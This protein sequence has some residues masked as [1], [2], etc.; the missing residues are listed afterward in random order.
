MFTQLPTELRLKV[1]EKLLEG[2]SFRTKIFLEHVPALQQQLPA[3]PGP[4]SPATKLQTTFSVAFVKVDE[5]H[6]EAP[7][8]VDLGGLLGVNK[9]IRGEFIGHLI[10]G[11]VDL[12]PSGRWIYSCTNRAR[13]TCCIELSRLVPE[14]WRPHI[15]TI[16][17]DEDALF[18]SRMHITG[19]ALTSGFP[20]LALVETKRYPV[21]ATKWHQSTGPTNLQIPS[22]KEL[23]TRTL[24]RCTSRLTRHFR[25]YN[26]LSSISSIGF[27]DPPDIRWVLRSDIG[28]LKVKFNE[29]DPAVTGRRGWRWDWKGKLA[30]GRP[31]APPRYSTF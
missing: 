2:S 1:Y 9:G 18:R 5:G 16:N 19:K 22:I 3:A 26:G 30:V 21:A 24:L 14:P 25:A 6:E 11:G 12:Q 28:C 15:T 4:A 31:P 8:T 7:M 10:K 17:L 13:C 20:E 23:H 27:Q 29:T